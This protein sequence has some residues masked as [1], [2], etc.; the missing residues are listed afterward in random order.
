MLLIEDDDLD[1]LPNITGIRAGFVKIDGINEDTLNK[2]LAS[3][4][5]GNVPILPEL[6]QDLLLLATRATTRRGVS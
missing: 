2:A 5:G 3:V 1:E 4:A 6:A